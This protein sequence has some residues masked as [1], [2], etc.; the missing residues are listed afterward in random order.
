MKALR[1]IRKQI[2]LPV[3]LM[4]VLGLGIAVFVRPAFALTLPTSCND[5]P[6][7]VIWCGAATPQQ[8][9]SD[10]T[11]GDGHNSAASIQNI[12]SFFGINSADI[13]ALPQTAVAGTVTK[14]GDVIVNGQTVATNAL[15]GGREYIQGSTR[16]DVNGTIFYVRPPSVSFLDNSL[17]AFVVMNNGKFAFA[18]LS[19]CGNAVSA[20]PVPS[21]TPTPTP[22]PN[23]TIE[24]QVEVTGSNDFS[25]EVQVKPDTDVTYQIT[26][27]S[28]GNATVQNLVVWDTLPSDD[29][30]DTNS[31]TLN[32]SSLSAT[33]AAQFFDGGL[34]LPDLAPGSQDVL[35]FSAT[36]GAN[37][38][39]S[40][41]VNET[42]PNT[43][44]MQATGLSQEKSTAT[45]SVEC[46]PTPPP[47]PTPT[48][49]PPATT[50]TVTTTPAALPSTG[51]GNVI[52]AFIGFSVAAGS[53][54]ALFMRRRIA[55]G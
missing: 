23:Y 18:I 46:T 3:T 34:T 48:P 22:V 27:N 43:A 42:L 12:Y 54:Y 11:R 7:E 6:N 4:A 52:G 20:T 17:D 37:V 15:T 53:G 25:S 41:C 26:I 31:L 10:Y 39:N 9:V 45:V 2:L 32:G 16:E 8:V 35:Q 55:K 44:Y 30:Y 50:T 5:A 1:K 21:P 14:S 13:S 33:Q 28:T 19:S 29:T 51:P 40:N 36:V 24:K 47:T 38:N 49:T